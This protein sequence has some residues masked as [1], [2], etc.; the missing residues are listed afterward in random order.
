MDENLRFFWVKDSLLLEIHS[1]TREHS[2]CSHIPALTLAQEVR[3]K[4]LQGL[5]LTDHHHVWAPHDLARLRKE[6]KLEEHFVLLSGQE[7]TT[8]DSGDVLV[9]GPAEAIKRHSKLSEILRKYPEA[10]VVW[11]HPYRN[12]VRPNPLLLEASGPF[13]GIEVFS[14][15][16]TI[17]DN[18]QGLQDWHR[19][20]FTALAGTDTHGE[21]Y[22]GTYP[23]QFDHWVDTLEDLV[24]EIRSGRCRPFFK[25]IPR[26]GANL[27][28]TE[29][30]VGTKGRKETRERWIIKRLH[31][32]SKWEK[33]QHAYRVM[34]EVFQKGFDRGRY[35]VP[36]PLDLDPETQTLIEVGQ[37][38]KSLYEM[39]L[40]V[41]PKEGRRL[42]ED[43]AAWLARFHRTPVTLS[44]PETFH[45]S[46]E[47]RIQNYMK[48]FVKCGHRHTR[49]AASLAETILAAEKGIADFGKEAFALGH[50]DFHPKNVLVGQDQAT[51]RS[52]LFVSAIDFENAQFYPHAYDVGTFLA[53]FRN[54]FSDSGILQEYTEEAFLEAYQQNARSLPSDFLRQVELFKARTNLSIASYLIKVGM[55]DSQDLWRV[56]VEAERSVALYCS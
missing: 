9:F 43:V 32:R 35:R 24:T 48:R 10:A 40:A 47:R 49:R 51:D 8:A 21:G 46:E 23:T 5:V 20:K 56:L 28:V 25:E 39:L 13:H 12:S 42:I 7:V 22:A 2:D 29:I 41:P 17:R 18:I 52:S 3:D 45:R 1:H 15:N 44:M 6:A 54:Q 50:G 36:E 27:Q 4:G 30:V 26:T 53:Q 16:H 11:A 38:G 55:G 34:E 33:A 19:H 14:S 31:G 37:R